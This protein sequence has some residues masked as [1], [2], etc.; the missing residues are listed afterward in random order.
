MIKVLGNIRFSYF[1]MHLVILIMILRHAIGV[2]P[3]WKPIMNDE[4][5]M[6]SPNRYEYIVCFILYM[7]HSF[8]HACNHIIKIFVF[9]IV[10]CMHK[11]L[12]LL[13]LKYFTIRYKYKLVCLLKLLLHFI[14]VT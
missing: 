12:F 11:P 9:I 14:S 13:A 4:T 7:Y 2:S 5:P 6:V 8:Y 1:Q 3:T 10:I